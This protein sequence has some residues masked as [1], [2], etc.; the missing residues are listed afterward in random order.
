[1]ARFFHVAGDARIPVEITINVGLCGAA[2]N[3]QLFGETKGAHAV[4]QP[5]VDGLGGAPLI[6]THFQR[7]DT[8]HFG[9]GGTVD[10][11]AVGKG[12]E[13]AFVRR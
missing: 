2:L 7:H 9:R 6:I 13:Q 10:V 8:E 3:A 11:F 12:I 5:E 4:D 1:M